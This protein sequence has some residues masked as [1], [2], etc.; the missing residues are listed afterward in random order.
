MVTQQ[1]GLSMSISNNVCRYGRDKNAG[2]GSGGGYS[3]GNY[4]HPWLLTPVCTH[5]TNYWYTLMYY[6]QFNSNISYGCIPLR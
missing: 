3:E 5:S 4:I 6:V 2:V 1:N